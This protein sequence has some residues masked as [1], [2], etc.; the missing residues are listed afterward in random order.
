MG[1]RNRRY[2]IQFKLRVTSFSGFQN[3][4]FIHS[5]F[6]S[7]IIISL[8]NF[9]LTPEQYAE[10]I[11]ATEYTY[12]YSLVIVGWRGEAEKKKFLLKSLAST[13]K[14]SI[15]QLISQVNPLAYSYLAIC[16]SISKTRDTVNNI[17]DFVF[18][19]NSIWE[20]INLPSDTTMR[21]IW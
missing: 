8:Y 1:I 18:I 19:V 10:Y 3:S 17:V 2:S 20:L 5:T 16:D 6:G 4:P 21:H 15:F 9:D 11:F 7:A 13:V 14:I 12:M